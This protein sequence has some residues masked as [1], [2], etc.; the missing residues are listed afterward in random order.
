M[1]PWLV[2]QWQSWCA[3][4]QRLGQ[5]YLLSGV[6]GLGL[7]AFAH[8]MAKGI[9]CQQSSQ[10]EACG[11]CSQ[12]HQ[13]EQATHPDYFPVEPLEGKKEISV[14]Q[15]RGLTDKIFSTSHQGGYKV[16]LIFA[17]EKL[18][19]SAFNALLKTLEE[20]PER[21]V[22]LLITHRLSKLPATLVSRCR[23]LDFAV[24]QR[25]VALEWLGQR[26]PQADAPLLSKAI[27]LNWGAPLSAS[28]WIET[29]AFE[30]EAQWRNDL[31]AIMNAKLSVPQAVEKWLKQDSPEIV[32]DYFY[33]WAVSRVRQALYQNKEP[34][35]SGWFG[36]QSAVVQA[37]EAWHH[38]VNKELLLESIGFHWQSLVFSTDQASDS[39]WP[40]AQF[41]HPEPLRLHEKGPY[42]RSHWV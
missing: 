36:F 30:F 37:K 35:Q 11:A 41:F 8:Q 27:T 12:C 14:D 22:L 3:Q 7:N 16:A 25:H 29:K 19:A 5:A 38:N 20:P 2:P 33:H 15:I 9:L 13:F 23:H 42:R 17:V 34:F 28:A 21:T 31:Q 10:G 24:P 4:F 6:E 1:Y 18:N 26:L 40:Y 32:L 39:R